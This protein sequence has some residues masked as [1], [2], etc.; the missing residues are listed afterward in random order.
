MLIEQMSEQP[1]PDEKNRGN[2]KQ[3]KLRIESQ[4]KIWNTLYHPCNQINKVTVKH[5]KFESVI[6]SELEGL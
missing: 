2:N 5:R 3:M 1:R 6:F 4:K